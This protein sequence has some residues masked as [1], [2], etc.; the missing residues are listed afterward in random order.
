MVRFTT[1]SRLATETMDM[2]WKE[3][4]F[5]IGAL[6]LGN[7]L[8]FGGIA[9]ILGLAMCVAGTVIVSGT[10]IIEHGGFIGSLASCITMFASAA[11]IIWHDDKKYMLNTKEENDSQ[12]FWPSMIAV[13]IIAFAI[14]GTWGAVTTYLRGDMALLPIMGWL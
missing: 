9:V 10:F 12:L 11:F 3:P 1:A 6:V 5:L 14:M 2:S 4:L 13:F 8:Y 7:V